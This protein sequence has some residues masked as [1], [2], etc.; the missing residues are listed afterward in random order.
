MDK[1][2]MDLVIAKL[3]HMDVKLDRVEIKQ[4]EQAVVL[5]K[6]TVIMDEHIRR[7]NLLEAEIRPIKTHVQVINWVAKIGLV[8]I[9]LAETLHRLGLF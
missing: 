7:T 8:L 6:N 3:D 1:E 2:I 4:S 5:A 9:G